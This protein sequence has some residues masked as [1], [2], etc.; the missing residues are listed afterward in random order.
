MTT[1]LATATDPAWHGGAGWFFFPFLWF[2]GFF[3]I[4]A[5]VRGIFWRRHWRHHSRPWGWSGGEGDPR[6]ILAGRYAR[7]EIDETE[8]RQRLAVLNGPDTP[9]K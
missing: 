5:L 3:L 7:G 9:R 1:L 4:I 8:Y 2:F 6:A